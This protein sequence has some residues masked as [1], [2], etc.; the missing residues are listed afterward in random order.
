MLWGIVSN[1]RV[2]S[3][4]VRTVGFGMVWHGTVRYGMVWYGMVWRYQMGCAKH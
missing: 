3:G 4:S 2:L 1:D